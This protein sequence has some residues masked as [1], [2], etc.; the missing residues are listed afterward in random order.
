MF[1]YDKYFFGQIKPSPL[2]VTRTELKT[3]LSQYLLYKIGMHL[4]LC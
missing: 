3:L 1:K 2:R 4:P